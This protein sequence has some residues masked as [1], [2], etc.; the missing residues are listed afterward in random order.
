MRSTHSSLKKPQKKKKNKTK[1]EYG[2]FFAKQCYII[3]YR[4]S[5]TGIFYYW[6]GREAGV[7]ETGT[8]ASL[9]KEWAGEGDFFFS[10][11][12]FFF[13]T[14][15]LCSWSESSQPG[16]CRSRQGASSLFALVPWEIAGLFWRTRR[17][18]LSQVC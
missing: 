10:C 13:L 1:S 7:T 14:V 15:Y 5:D 16:S 3:L 6:I 8:A 2:T 9:A 4:Y 12:T 18:A 17:A 11:M